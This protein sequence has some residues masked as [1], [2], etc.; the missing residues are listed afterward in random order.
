M[1]FAL[2]TRS[3]IV[4]FIPGHRLSELLYTEIVAPLLRER[5]PDLPYAA[6]LLGSG[7]DVLGYDTERSMDH[8]WGPRLNILIAEADLQSIKPAILD[9]LDDALPESFHGIPINVPGSIQ[10]P[11]DE[12][13]LHH[14]AG[15]GRRHGVRIDCLPDLL[16]FHVHIR[17]IDEFDIAR[18]LATPQQSLLELLAGPLWHDAT[19]E[20]TAVREGIAWYPDDLWR[21]QMAARWKRIA[22]LEAFVGRCGELGDDTG[23]QIITLCLVEDAMKLALLQARQYAP[24]EKWLGTAFNRLKTAPALKPH[25]DRAR[26]GRDWRER[27]TGLIPALRS[28][29]EEHNQLGITDPVEARVYQF[30]DRPFQVIFAE[31][32]SRALRASIE[33]DEILSLP[34]DLGGID[35]FV[36]TTDALKHT[37]LR[38]A[39]AAWFRTM[40]TGET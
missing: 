32:F 13:V 2:Y 39:L 7:S 33:D 6:A 30:H 20:L 11:G 36:D 29:A 12:K 19:G 1:G 8:D 22:Q 27:E 10:I 31:R 24:Y 21:Y 23:S 14:A 3:Q 37:G 5:F 17:S 38:D 4:A 18:W 34:E 26:F 16:Q 35:Q 40:T 9:A 28:L 15:S 25:F